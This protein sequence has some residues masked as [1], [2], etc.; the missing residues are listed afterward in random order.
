MGPL[1]HPLPPHLTTPPQNI[2][3]PLY[4]F[5]NI[6]TTIACLAKRSQPCTR[7]L[8]RDNPANCRGSVQ[9]PKAHVHTSLLP[10]PCN[11]ATAKVTEILPSRLHFKSSHIAD[12]QISGVFALLLKHTIMEVIKRSIVR[13][14]IKILRLQLQPQQKLCKLGI[15]EHA[16]HFSALETEAR[17]LEKQFQTRWAIY[18]DLVTYTH[19]HTHKLVFVFSQ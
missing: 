7:E 19:T 10:A 17:G 9:A 12:A 15:E 3:P 4:L 11:H 14:S 5:I 16:W 18:R 1:R 6:S 13:M 2:L 8:T